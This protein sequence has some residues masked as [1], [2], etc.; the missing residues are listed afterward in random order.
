MLKMWYVFQGPQGTPYATG[1]YYGTLS[2]PENYPLAP[3][4]VQ[5]L[6][7]SGRFA[8]G[9]PIHHTR[10]VFES[11]NI[12]L[13]KEVAVTGEVFN[14]LNVW[15]NMGSNGHDSLNLKMLQR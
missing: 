1:W 14:M 11:F 13:S 9:L 6:T 5:M 12:I 7:P 8:T 4:S 2:F 15:G 10:D 3:P